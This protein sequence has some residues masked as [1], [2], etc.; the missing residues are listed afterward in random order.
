MET[1]GEN[2]RL[3]MP[4]APDDQDGQRELSDR[5]T[6]G[7]RRFQFIEPIAS[8]KTLVVVETVNRNSG[9]FSVD[10]CSRKQPGQQER[11]HERNQYK[12]PDAVHHRN[13]DGD[14][15]LHQDVLERFA[16]THQGHVS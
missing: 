1:A 9:V 6:A 13:H 3:K 4:K 15:E 7:L 12:H 14:Q 8:S 5:G 11:Q 2:R 16:G 10:E